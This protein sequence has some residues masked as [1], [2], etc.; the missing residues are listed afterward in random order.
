MRSERRA[1]LVTGAGGQLGTALS[2]REWPGAL[3]PVPRDHAALD[4]CRLGAV[5]ETLQETQPIAVVNAAAYTAVD[6]AESDPAR[7]FAVNRDGAANV[8]L[9]C[10]EAGIPLVHVSTDYVFDGTATRPYTEADEVSPINL[11]G[12]SK[13]AG[14]DAV[15]A[16]LAEHVILRTAWVYGPYGRNVATAMLR[17]AAETGELAVVDDQYGCPT[18]V[19]DL[20]AAIVA[21]LDRLVAGGAVRWGTFHYCGS[22]AMT[23]YAFA[24]RLFDA[25]GARG[26]SK[27]SLRAVSTAEYG[28]RAARPAYSVLDTSRFEGALGVRARPLDAGL[29][30]CLGGLSL[31]EQVVS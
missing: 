14:E 24:S 6:A 31:D 1:V 5:R 20:A 27:P 13:A 21:A 18:A 19:D 12:A 23:W 9:A 30:A 28:A 26:G 2:R 25:A 3:A 8:A 29:A 7:A 16:R 17:R 15:R 22:E 11:Y 4:I 10:A